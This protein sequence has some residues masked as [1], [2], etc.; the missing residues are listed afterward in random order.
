MK[1]QI[2]KFIFLVSLFFSVQ[3][4][5]NSINKIDFVG[6]DTIPSSSLIDLLPV[7]IGDQYNE[8]ISNKIIEVLFKTGYFSDIQIDVDHNNLVI[9]LVEN[10]IVK[11]F[12]VKTGSG[13]AWSDWLN[14]E[15]DFLNEEKINE[16]I[17]Y[18]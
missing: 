12:D 11:Y 16:Y 15:S 10:P 5:A 2:I 4:L 18:K 8:Q 7:E 17:V 6:L 3:S 14:A 9:T 1:N 13:S